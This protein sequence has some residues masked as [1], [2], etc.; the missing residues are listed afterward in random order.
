MLS[1]AKF[2]PVPPVYNGNACASQV[3]CYRSLPSPHL[4]R[5]NSVGSSHVLLPE[6]APQSKHEILQV[7]PMLARKPLL[8]QPMVRIRIV[9]VMPRAKRDCRK[10]RG[11]LPQASWPQGVR[12]C[13]FDQV[14]PGLADRI[15]SIATSGQLGRN[16]HKVSPP[17]P[18]FQRAPFPGAGRRNR[19]QRG[20]N[21]RI[22]ARRPAGFPLV[23]ETP[24]AA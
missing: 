8:A 14:I 18:L 16:L 20:W 7:K 12:V 9:P 11:L 24:A 15:D 23:R 13:G 19:Q 22:G 5:M 6:S 21:G 17:H 2:A 3:P 4:H 10:V 1:R